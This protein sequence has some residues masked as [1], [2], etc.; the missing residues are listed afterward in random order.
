MLGIDINTADILRSFVIGEGIFV[1]SLSMVYLTMLHRVDHLRP[2]RL[3]GYIGKE[4]C[5]LSAML[6]TIAG[7]YENL[8][9]PMSWRTLIALLMVCAGSFGYFMLVGNLITK[10]KWFQNKFLNK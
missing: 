8:G 6:Y 5:I 9:R 4:V 7:T 10:T 2:E 1:A 3:S